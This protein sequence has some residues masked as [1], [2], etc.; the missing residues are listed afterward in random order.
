MDLLLIDW[1]VSICHAYICILLYVKLI[2]CSGGAWIYY[3]L[4]RGVHLPCVCVHSSICETFW[5]SGVAW[6]YDQL[7][8][9]GPS[10]RH[11]CAFCYMWNWFGVVVLHGSMINWS[12]GWVSLSWKWC[13]VMV[14]ID[15]GSIYHA[16]MCML[17]CVKLIQCSGVAWIYDWLTRGLCHVYMCI[18]L[19]VKLMQCSGVAW[20]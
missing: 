18:L 4:S 12:R 9:G 20:I 19:D 7:K 17:L 13:S 16:Y 1:G 11:I 14:S 8:E 2:W 10:A 6:I 3:R 5:C 15:G